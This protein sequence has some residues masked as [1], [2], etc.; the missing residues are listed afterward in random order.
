MIRKQISRRWSR[1][2]AVLVAVLC[3]CC[4]LVNGN[5]DAKRLYDDLLFQN[6]Y[7]VLIRPVSNPKNNLTVEVNLKLSALVDV[8]S[9]VEMKVRIFKHILCTSV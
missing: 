3:A 7:N 9:K 6:E 5:P 1:L 2:D 8:V 4:H